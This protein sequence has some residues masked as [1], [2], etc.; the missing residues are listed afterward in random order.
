MHSMA[1]D[2]RHSLAVIAGH[3]EVLNEVMTGM[4]I[5]FQHSMEAT[6]TASAARREV[7]HAMKAYYVLEPCQAGLVAGAHRTKHP[8]LLKL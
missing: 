4:E 6:D 5:L 8:M 1:A 7:G 3:Q 2:L